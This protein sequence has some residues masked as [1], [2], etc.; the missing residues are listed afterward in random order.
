M[1]QNVQ[2]IYLYLYLFLLNV[3]LHTVLK[4]QHQYHIIVCLLIKCA[5]YQNN[6]YYFLK[7]IRNL[8]NI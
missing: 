1:L 2:Y 5:L 6:L 7:L 4:K 3:F 8:N